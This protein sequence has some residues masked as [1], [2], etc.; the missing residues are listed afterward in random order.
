MAPMT[1]GSYKFLLKHKNKIETNKSE[2]S[3][4]YEQVKLFRNHLQT[5]MKIKLGQ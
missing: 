2:V 1:I 3:Y 5:K 4:E